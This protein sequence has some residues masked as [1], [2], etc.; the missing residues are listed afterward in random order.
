MGGGGFGEGLAA[1]GMV[2]RSARGGTGRSARR[3]QQRPGAAARQCAARRWRR[4]RNRGGAGQRREGRGASR[5][6]GGLGRPAWWCGEEEA[7]GCGDGEDG[8]R[9][10][11]WRGWTGVVGKGATRRGYRGRRRRRCARLSVGRLRVAVGM[12]RCADLLPTVP[13]RAIASRAAEGGGARAPPGD[14]AWGGGGRRVHWRQRRKGRGPAR[15]RPARRWRWARSSA[16]E[17]MT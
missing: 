16:R 7:D 10:W 4:G 2:V 3:Q 15:L 5:G 14:A 17:A 12:E 9:R 13:W 6:G 11:G 8:Q 1:A